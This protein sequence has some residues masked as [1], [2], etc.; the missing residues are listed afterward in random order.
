M[1]D[2]VVR[3]FFLQ[4][5]H[6]CGQSELFFFSERQRS[7]SVCLYVYV[8]MFIYM[9][10]CKIASLSACVPKAYEIEGRCHREI[11]DI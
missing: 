4:V 10:I 3:C 9:H 2:M 8:C 5:R 6:C 1:L 11:K 7:F